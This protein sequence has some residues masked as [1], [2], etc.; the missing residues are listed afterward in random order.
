MRFFIFNLFLF[1]NFCFFTS[2]FAQAEADLLEIDLSFTPTSVEV[3]PGGK[4]LILENP[5]QYEIW[6]IEN[7]QKI[8]SNT[9]KY[10]APKFFK[11][12]ISGLSEGSGYFFFRRVDIF[13]IAV[14]KITNKDIKSN[15]LST[16]KEKIGRASCRK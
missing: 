3:S 2:V 13:L 12:Q 14:Y 10:T 11:M 6:N 15:D 5:G 9:Y 16:G 8:I 7:Q 1:F 4:Y